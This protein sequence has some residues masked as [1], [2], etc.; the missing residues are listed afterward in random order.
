MRI[1]A[2]SDIH[3]RNDALERVLDRHPDVR[4][5]VF[6]GDGLSGVEEVAAR[7][8]S[9]AF[10]CVPGNCDHAP[11]TPAVAVEML[12]GDNS[13]Y[14]NTG[15]PNMLVYDTLKKVWQDER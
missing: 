5:V 3:G 10:I 9:H 2:V 6:L 12:G 4:T 13:E 7:R 14:F 1:L 15:N 11:L 8:P